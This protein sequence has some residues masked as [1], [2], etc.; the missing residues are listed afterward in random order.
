MQNRPGTRQLI[1]GISAHADGKDQRKGMDSGMDG[2]QAKPVTMTTLATLT[3]SDVALGGVKVKAEAASSHQQ[4]QQDSKMAPRQ[5]P[6]VLIAS[7]VPTMKPHAA[8]GVFDQQGWNVEIV[9]DGAACLRELQKRNWNFVLID[10]DLP[11]MSG[12][13][14]INAFREWERA[15]RVQSQKHVVLVSE[16][17]LSTTSEA[18]MYAQ[19]P[20]GFN[21]VLSKPVSWGDLKSL[22][23]NSKTDG[24]M[25]II[26]R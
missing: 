15:N 5:V 22:I 23:A 8:V 16:G 3:G 19:P 9:N 24:K 1:I 14:C 20:H 12:V 21:G 10:D 18:R 11:D 17:Y 25:D 2:F 6:V 4:Q 26:V 7:D 13:E